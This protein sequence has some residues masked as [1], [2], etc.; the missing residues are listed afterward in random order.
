MADS[1]K[2]RLKS[3]NQIGF[4][5]P[6]LDRAMEAYWHRFGIGPWRIY[7]YGSPLVK[8]TTYRGQQEDYHIRIALAEVNGL[9]I[10][11]IQHLDGNTVHKEFLER[12]G[13][14][15]Q[16]LGLF[17]ENLDLAVKEM[18]QAG[19]KVV[20]AGCGYGARGDGAYAYVDT[21][22]ELGVMYELI[23]LPAERV[24]PEGVYPSETANRVAVS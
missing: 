5:V 6:D 7:S 19:F 12:A 15:V 4:V 21:E 2:F 13:K 17:V 9:V 3:I 24:P 22:E 8:G 1:S 18:Q 20:Q 10:E 23:Q 14:G 11:L 16:H